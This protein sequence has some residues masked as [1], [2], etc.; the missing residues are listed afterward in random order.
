MQQAVLKE[1]L[2]PPALRPPPKKNEAEKTNKLLSKRCLC[3]IAITR[4][5]KLESHQIFIKIWKK[6]VVKV[7]LTFIHFCTLLREQ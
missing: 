6:F 5:K 4:T 7:V 2:T 1:T 3:C